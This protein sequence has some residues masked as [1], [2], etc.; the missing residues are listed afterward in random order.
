V[1]WPHDESTNQ[2]Q[3][4]PAGVMPERS[5]QGREMGNSSG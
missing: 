2:A 1:M 3:C 4:I 5:W